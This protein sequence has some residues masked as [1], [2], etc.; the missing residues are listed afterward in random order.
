MYF[1]DCVE[2][3]SIMQRVF[4]ETTPL[5]DKD[6]LYIVERYKSEF[7]F[8]LH[9]HEEFELNFIE[10]GE[11]V[12]RVV[13]DSIETIGNYDLTLVA[14]KNLEHA[15]EQ[16][17]CSRPDVRE[18]TIQFSPGLF[19]E[20]FLSRN[21]FASIKR[22]LG[23]SAHGLNFSMAAIMKVYSLLDTLAKDDGRFNQFLS[24]LKILYELSLDEG[25]R[26]L[27]STTFA[28]ADR[29]WGSR[30]VNKVKEYVSGHY[31]DDIKLDEVAALV[32]MTPSSFSRFFRQHTGRTLSDFIIDIRLGEAARMLVDTS[33]GISEI[34]YCCGFN[35]LSNFNRIFKARRGCTPRDFRAIYA[36]NRVFV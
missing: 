35:N 7:L 1:C 36:K 21:Q 6:C 27:A 25:A 19:G 31:A 20:G 34:C 9:S 17:T 3:V 10:G 12:V 11:G 15:W 5:S 23:R 13:G 29:D 30:R 32:G 14:G 22:M 28:H 16:G 8:P 18:I 33:S 2:I 4:V 24:F 26:E